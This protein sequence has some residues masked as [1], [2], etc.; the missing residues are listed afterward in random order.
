MLGIIGECAYFLE[1]LLNVSSVAD[2]L[3]FTATHNS[4]ALQSGDV[5][6]A[7]SAHLEKRKPVFRDSRM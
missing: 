5:K 3:A 7:L 4:V 6:E 2:S 1:G